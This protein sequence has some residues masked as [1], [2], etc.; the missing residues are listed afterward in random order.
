MVLEAVI[1]SFISQTP[2]V[3]PT[4]NAP[5]PVPAVPTTAALADL[6][7]RTRAMRAR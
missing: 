5:I 2:V 1:S 6:H 7:M 4:T 3:S